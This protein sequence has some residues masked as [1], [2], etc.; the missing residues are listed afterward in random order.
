MIEFV[1]IVGGC[2][3]RAL[4][5][6]CRRLATGLAAGLMVAC[7]VPIAE[8]QSSVRTTAISVGAARAKYGVPS[9]GEH[10]RLVRAFHSQLQLAYPHDEEERALRS[11][12]LTAAVEAW[13]AA[14]RSAA[15]E[16][17][18]DDWLR[19]AIR[20]SMPGSHEPLPD[21]PK[22]DGPVVVR[23]AAG[24][25]TN[26]A[27]Q[28]PSPASVTTARHKPLDRIQHAVRKPQSVISSEAARL[29]LEPAATGDG[30]SRSTTP[31]VETD[32]WSSHPASAGLPA[33][34]ADPFR[35]DP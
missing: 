20:K 18:L 35:D 34:L 12:Q 11:E 3:G 6:C 7:L 4:S 8:A 22:F 13:R 31:S 10:Q 5:S 26:A 25:T 17:L 30:E 32:F 23:S 27:S 14:T 33:E 19:T 2:R 24:P 21:I 29:L 9:V 28:K 16:R 15:N 1:Q